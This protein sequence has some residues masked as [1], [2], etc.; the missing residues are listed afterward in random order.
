MLT[1]DDLQ[2]IKNIVVTNNNILGTI[3]KVELAETNKRIDKLAHEVKK[4]NHL[5]ERVEVLEM[6]KK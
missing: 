2:A 6:V 1:K 3:I 5:E 4:I